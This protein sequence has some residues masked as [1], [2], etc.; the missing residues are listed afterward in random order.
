MQYEKS[1]SKKPSKKSVDEYSLKSVNTSTMLW[2]IVK[3]HK[4]A[5][6]CVLAVLG[7]ALYLWPSLPYD[8]ADMV[9]SI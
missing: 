4:F 9:R 1:G 2:H 6:V 7:W 5:I 3:R 8:F